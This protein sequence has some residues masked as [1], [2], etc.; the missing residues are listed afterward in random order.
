MRWL[1]LILI[2]FL[3]ACQPGIPSASPEPQQVE[4]S[5]P[6]AATIP[7]ATEESSPVPQATLPPAG[8]QESYPPPQAPVTTSG[9]AGYP[10]PEAKITWEEAREL[11][12]DGQVSQVTQLH[13]LR[14]I[15]VLKDGRTVETDEPLSDEVFAV[16]DECGEVCSDIVIATE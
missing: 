7:V 1:G 5:S 16:I 10:A 4:P 9:E 8:T 6:P 13:S 3:A 12:L 14:V 15:L 11:I 2:L